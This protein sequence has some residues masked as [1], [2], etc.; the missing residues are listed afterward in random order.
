[1]AASSTT[2]ATGKSSLAGKA[3]FDDVGSV[4]AN[5]LWVWVVVVAIGILV[6]I[7]AISQRK[8]EV[9]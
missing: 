2:S 1:M 8:K 4:V 9:V 7:Y 6:A 5:Y 3:F